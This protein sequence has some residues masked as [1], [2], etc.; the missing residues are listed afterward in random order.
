MVT[1]KLS[2]PWWEGE[3]RGRALQIVSLAPTATVLMGV[4]PLK[5][6]LEEAELDHRL[7]DLAFGSHLC[8]YNPDR[9]ADIQVDDDTARTSLRPEKKTKPRI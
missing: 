2:G 6:A 4:P 8:R 7:R 5:P 1:E 3:I 9:T